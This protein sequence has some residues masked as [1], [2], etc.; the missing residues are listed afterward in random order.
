MITN[1]LK[2]NNTIVLEY[3]YSRIRPEIIPYSV[4][5]ESNRDGK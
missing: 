1:F 2:N 4:K 3:K 5:K